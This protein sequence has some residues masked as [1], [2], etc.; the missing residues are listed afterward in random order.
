M[1]ELFIE[2]EKNRYEWAFDAKHDFMSRFQLYDAEG[3]TP[4]QEKVVL[5]VYGPTQV[6]KTTLI[7]NLLGVKEEAIDEISSFLRGKREIG[8]SATVTVTSYSVSAT[9]D[10]VLTL[11][12]QE[13]E[14]IQ[15][16][17]ILEER[18]SALRIDVEAGRIDSLAP[19]RIALPKSYF[20]QADVAIE[21]LDL[22][23]IES[24]EERELR[25]VERC[26]NH[27]IPRSHI[28][29]IV[30]GAGDLTFLR[31]IGM[32][33]LQHWYD[34]P[35]NFYVVLTR[36]Y[37]PESV[38]RRLRDKSISNETDLRAYYH[39][40]IGDILGRPPGTV[41]P[42]EI[43]A[44]MHRLEPDAREIAQSILNELRARI[45]QTDYR[46][47]SFSFL[48]GY[49]AEVV[50]QSDE[51]IRHITE[52]LDVAE[53]ELAGLNKRMEKLKEKI[54]DQ[55][56]DFGNQAIELVSK[57]DHF[58]MVHEVIH[59]R[60]S[61]EVLIDVALIQAQHTKSRTALNAAFSQAI[62]MLEKSLDED[63][64][65]INQLL[66]T[67]YFELD[68]VDSTRL[69]VTHPGEIQFF[70]WDDS[71]VDRY[72]SQKNYEAQMDWMKKYL[73]EETMRLSKLVYDEA[74]HIYKQL[75]DISETF[76]SNRVRLDIRYTHEMDMLKVELNEAEQSV[77]QLQERLTSTKER[78]EEDLV[79]A[80]QYRS[81]FI[82][83]FAKR[84]QELLRQAMSDDIQE[85][86]SAGLYLYTLGRDAEEIIQALGCPNGNETSHDSGRR[87]L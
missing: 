83:H 70:A 18:L 54:E 44:S 49:Y 64:E 34:Y 30:N 60:E 69:Q 13:P 47:V 74:K 42:V 11:P 31:D 68:Y 12:N 51:E 10:Y 86:Y 36:A 6:G 22:P 26:V 5:S 23:G 53:R 24:A 84:Q 79:H 37:S 58:K 20:E 3:V 7:L 81:F 21:L 40:E 65:M 8:Q 48:T 82:E 72:F 76:S 56:G 38:K 59:N 19:V 78:W 62:S 63:V 87:A 28:C 52:D 57:I 41:Y 66:N 46:H 77:I 33:H 71:K 80:Q 39:R 73:L 9:E 43:G 29:L 32:T 14:V 27:W 2:F 45:E 25:H 85:R 50:R 1:R 4:N 55:V 61:K 35:D 67:I 15:S 75:Q 17:D 16:T